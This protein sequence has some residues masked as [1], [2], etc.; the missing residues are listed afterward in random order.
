MK[1]MKIYY[2]LFR[3]EFDKNAEDEDGGVYPEIERCFTANVEHMT[4]NYSNAEF[5]LKETIKSIRR[6]STYE[7]LVLSERYTTNHYE[8]VYKGGEEEKYDI[9]WNNVVIPDQEEELA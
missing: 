7:D 4:T 2:I 5:Y 3:H 9:C 1:T 6:Q 8:I